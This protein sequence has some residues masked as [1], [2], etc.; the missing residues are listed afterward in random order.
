[1]AAQIQFLDM[2]VSVTPP[3]GYREPLPVTLGPNWQPND[4]RLVFVTGSGSDSGS[5]T[6]LEMVMY[7]DPPTTFTAAYT[8]NVGHDTHGVYYR[9]LVSGD[10]DTSIAWVKPASWRHFMFGLLTVR[11]VSPSTTPAAGSLSFSQ[12]EGATTVTVSS[13][14]VPNAGTMVMF[15]GSVALPPGGSAWPAWPVSMGVPTGWTAMVA[16]DKSGAHFYQYDTNPSIVV[17]GKS[18][19]TSGS[20]GSVAFPTAQGAPAYTGLYAFLTPGADAS[21]AVGAA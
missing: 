14:T 3:G 16:T 15:G 7:P 20:T 21:V 8:R 4:I 19:S 1:M 2:S 5:D 13:V 17:V 18:Y 12:V 10:A 6:A 11:G 9:R